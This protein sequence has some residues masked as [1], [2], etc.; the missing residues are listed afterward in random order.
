[1]PKNRTFL[2]IF[3]NNTIQMQKSFYRLLQ[4]SCFLSYYGSKK[5]QSG[6]I[7]S[8]SLYFTL[9]SSLNGRKKCPKITHFSSL[10]LPYIKV[11]RWNKITIICVSQDV[12]LGIID[13]TKEK[14]KDFQHFRSI[15][16]LKV[17]EKFCII[18]IFSELLSLKLTKKRNGRHKTH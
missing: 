14:Q 5:K 11:L 3:L 12:I 17:W 16:N 2:Q 13:A 4:N 1:M 8:V 9:I 7:S 10:F 6:R 18:C 15:S